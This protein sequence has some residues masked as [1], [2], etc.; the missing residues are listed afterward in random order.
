MIDEFKRT[1]VCMHIASTGN[2]TQAAKLLFISQPALSLYIM[3][4]GKHPW[5]P[6]V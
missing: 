2:I 3:Q 5:N 6:S 4:S 1:A